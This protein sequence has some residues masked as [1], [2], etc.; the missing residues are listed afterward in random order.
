MGFRLLVLFVLFLDNVF[1]VDFEFVFTSGRVLGD[2]GSHL[3]HVEN[4]KH[5]IKVQMFQVQAFQD[6]LCNNEVYVLLLQFDLL[7]KLQELSLGDRTFPITLG[8]Q[9]R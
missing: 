1:L 9:C 7:E 6:N 8:C 2:W 4:L 5:G 3:R